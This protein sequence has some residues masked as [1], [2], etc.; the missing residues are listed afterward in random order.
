MSS[1]SQLIADAVQPYISKF[2]IKDYK[3]TLVLTGEISEDGRVVNLKQTGE[4]NFPY[5]FTSGLIEQFF[6]V[7]GL[8]PATVNGKPVRQKITITFA[9]DAGI[10]RFSY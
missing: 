2:D 9:F 3:N 1:L 5:N 7:S 4:Y 8:L 6:H 10:Y